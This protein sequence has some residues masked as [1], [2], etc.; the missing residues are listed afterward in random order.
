MKRTISRVKMLATKLVPQLI[1][2]TPVIPGFS[3]LAASSTYARTMTASFI[4][5]TRLAVSH[6][7]TRT[8]T[9]PC[10][11]VAAQWI[12]R[13]DGEG[14]WQMVMNI[15]RNGEISQDEFWEGGVVGQRGLRR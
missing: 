3:T 1:L 11:A 14:R 13:F 7:V 8:G 10:G 9:A 15:S 2:A 5:A 6:M 12:H 4:H